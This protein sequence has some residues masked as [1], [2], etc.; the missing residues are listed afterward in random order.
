MAFVCLFHDRVIPHS[1]YVRHLL[2]SFICWWRLGCFHVFVI[3]NGAAMNIGV[4]VSLSVKILSGYMPSHGIAESY[5]SSIFSFLRYLHIVFHSSCTNLYSYQQW[6]RV[7]LS[8]YPLKHL[9]FVDLLMTAIQIGVRWYLIVVLICISLTI[10]DIEYFL[11]CL[12]AICMSSLEKCLFRS[13]AHFSIGL[14]VCFFLLLSF[15][16]C[17]YILE[18]RPLCVASLAKIFLPFCGFSFHFFFNGFLC[19]VEAFEFD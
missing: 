18:I 8:P 10:S 7:P 3:V 19:C 9:L 17:S 14:F 15:K 1:V 13:Y 2:N 11:I 16:C 6:R 5:G 12:L 4:Y